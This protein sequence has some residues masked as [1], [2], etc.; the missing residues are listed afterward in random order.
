MKTRT[1]DIKSDCAYIIAIGDLHV[2]DKAFGQESRRK[3]DGYIKW[4]L[5]HDSARVILNGDLVN[6][7]TRTSKTSPFEQDMDLE[8]QITEVARLLMPV[9]DRIIGSVMGNHERRIEDQAGFDPT[10]AILW[11][12]GLNTEEVYFKY[13]GILKVRVGKR[14]SVGAE[15]MKN[16]YTVVFNHTTGGGKLIGSK[17]NRVDQMRESTITN[18]DVYIGSH[19]HSLSAGIM[20]SNEY[21]GHSETVEQRKQTLVSAGGYL[22]WNDSYAEVMQL[23][24][25]KIGSPRIRL[26]GKGD[27]DVHV[28]L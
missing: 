26:E 21:N 22:E 23:Q 14:M 9:K 18:A 2:G 8:E 12:L 27:K 11:K 24:P 28:S 5:E 3:L 7:A 10:L 25:T 13:T 15:K 6:C 1:I 17:L 20:I 19:N 16:A 4:I